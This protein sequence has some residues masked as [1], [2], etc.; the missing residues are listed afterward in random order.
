MLPPS[1]SRTQRGFTLVE[2]LVAMVVGSVLMT[3]LFRIW[4]QNRTT[5]EMIA[6]KGDLR[7]RVTLATTQVNRSI[8]MAGFGIENMEVVRRAAGSLTDTLVVYS[9]ESERRTTLVDSAARNATSIRVFKDS[10]LAVGGL[11]GITDSLQ[12][13]YARIQSISGNEDDGFVVALS[14]P[15]ANAYSAGVPDIYPVTKERFFADAQGKALVRYVGDRRQT[16]GDGITQFKVQLLDSRG[17]PAATHK[18]IRVITFSLVGS[19]KASTGTSP[20]VLSFSSTVIPRNI[21]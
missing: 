4:N 20:G 11:L 13:E 10:G 21:L 12:H 15:L 14:G 3:G 17:N 6:N 19:Y 8:T 18:D 5:T 1:P 9:N 7:D 16:L 2:M